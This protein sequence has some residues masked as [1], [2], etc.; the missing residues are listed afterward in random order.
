MRDRKGD[1]RRKKKWEGVEDNNKAKKNKYT[2]E[3]DIN[4]M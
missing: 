1:R 3:N 2:K 4:K